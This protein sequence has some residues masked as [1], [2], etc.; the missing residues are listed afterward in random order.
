MSCRWHRPHRRW[1]EWFP[2]FSR[3]HHAIFVE[4]NLSAAHPALGV[5]MRWP[6]H[7][8]SRNFAAN[9]EQGST[10]VRW[11]ASSETDAEHGLGSTAKAATAFSGIQCVV[12]LCYVF[13][14]FFT[15]FFALFLLIQAANSR[16]SSSPGLG[17]RMKAS[18]TRKALTALRRIR[19]TSSEVKMPDSVTRMRVA[20]ICAH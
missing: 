15:L 12:Q 3:S 18:P 11:S 1:H 13:A 2:S 9:T 17:A 19:A 6:W 20:G 4:A 5:F 8:R 16:D 14:L 10:S 7:R